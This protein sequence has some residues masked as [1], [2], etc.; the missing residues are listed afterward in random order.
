MDNPLSRRLLLTT[1]CATLALPALAGPPPA[2]TPL[3]VTR[4]QIVVNGK[5]AS[6]FGITGPGQKPGLTLAPGAR[7]AVTVENQCGADTIIHWHGQTPPPAQDGVTDTGYAQPIAPAAAQAYDFTA[8]PGTHWM[9]SHQ[10]LQEQQL[11]AAP[12][13]V[14]DADGA[15]ADVQDEVVMLHDF[16]FRDPAEI[17][18]GLIAKPGGGMMGNMGGMMGGGMDMPMDI[19][20]IDFDAYLANDR[21]LED[22]Q[23]IAAAPGA[24]IRLRLINAASA[25]GFWIDLGGLTGQIIAVDGNAVHPVTVSRFPLASAQRADVLLRL[26]GAGAFPILAQREGARER[27]G[28]IIATPNAAILQLDGLAAAP[29]PPCDLSLETRLTAAVPLTPRVPD[30]L[31]QLQLTGGMAGYDWGINGRQWANRQTL[32]VQPG[33]RVAFDLANA[34]MMSHPMHLHGHHFQLAGINGVAMKGAV[35]DTVLVPPM[36]TMRIV[37]DAA[38]PGRWLF[39]CHNLYHMA[40]GMMTELVYSAA[41]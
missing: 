29:A 31:V 11:M 5:A 9:H 36:G 40:A 6:M 39:H 18:A 23:I 41:S 30:Q 24:N 7:F 14:L 25:T 28:I 32:T 10:G 17:L 35:R 16:T 15:Q 12:L 38:N 22:P 2:V 4:R 21:T 3:T 26:P 19:N 27:T 37:F 13:I 8:R 20:D 34:S 1:G 33:Q